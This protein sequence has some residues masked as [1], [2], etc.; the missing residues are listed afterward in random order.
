MSLFLILMINRSNQNYYFIFLPPIESTNPP[1]FIITYSTLKSTEYMK[2]FLF[3]F[4]PKIGHWF[5][6]H[7]FMKIC[8]FT[9]PVSYLCHFFL[10]QILHKT[11]SGYYK[12]SFKNIFNATFTSRYYLTSLLFYLKK[13]ILLAFSTLSPH[14]LSSTNIPN[15]HQLFISYLL[16]EISFVKVTFIRPILM[17]ISQS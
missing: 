12:T 4:K 17:V 11:S 14:I 1:I 5:N 16:S 15:M 9:Y 6:P 3:L 10:Q 2:L 13:V 8:S 7:L